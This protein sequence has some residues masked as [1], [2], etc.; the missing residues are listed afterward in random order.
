MGLSVCANLSTALSPSAGSP[1]VARST[2]KGRREAPR[3]R[4]K[5]SRGFRSEGEREGARMGTWLGYKGTAGELPTLM[6]AKGRKD[7]AALPKIEPFPPIAK[8][9]KIS[10]GRSSGH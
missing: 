1:R 2:Q 4:E 8:H 7:P 6:V 9:C 3:K 5:R 10:G